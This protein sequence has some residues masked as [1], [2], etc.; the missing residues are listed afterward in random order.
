LLELAKASKHP[1]ALIG[2]IRMDDK[3]DEKIIAY[4]VVGSDLFNLSFV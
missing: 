3:F 4:Q 2:G 1:V